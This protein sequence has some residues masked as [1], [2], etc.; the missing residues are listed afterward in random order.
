V[1]GKPGCQLRLKW[2]TATKSEQIE[3]IRN[4]SKI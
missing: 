2:V 4:S 1:R 3:A